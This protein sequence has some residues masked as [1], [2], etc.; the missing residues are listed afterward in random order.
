MSNNLRRL[1]TLLYNKRHPSD[2]AAM[3]VSVDL[4]KA[5][6]TVR[7]DYLE[8]VM[9]RVGFRP[10]WGRGGLN[11]FTPTLQQGSR[12]GTRYPPVT[13]STK[14]LD[15]A[16]RSRFIMIAGTLE[17]ATLGRRGPITH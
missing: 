12:L 4:E 17:R 16:A 2:P 14:G 9:L 1:Y 8:A 11:Y 10:Y 5:F 6:D 13:I 7:W 3:I 15:R